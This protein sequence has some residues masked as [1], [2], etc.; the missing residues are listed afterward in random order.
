MLDKLCS[1][2][3]QEAKTRF[4]LMLVISGQTDLK[5]LLHSGPLSAVSGLAGKRRVPARR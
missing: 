5:E 2:I 4:G 3:A 1:L